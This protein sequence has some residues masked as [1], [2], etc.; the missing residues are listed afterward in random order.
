MKVTLVTDL[1]ARGIA[2]VVIVPGDS[3]MRWQSNY[4]ATGGQEEQG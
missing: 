1:L 3:V 2:K 4:P